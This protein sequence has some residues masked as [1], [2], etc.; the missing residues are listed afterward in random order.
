M[1]KAFCLS[2]KIGYIMNLRKALEKEEASLVEVGRDA[3]LYYDSKVGGTSPSYG[4]LTGRLD[5][6]GANLVYDF[7]MG[8]IQVLP[9]EFL[10]NPDEFVIKSQSVTHENES[11]LQNHRNYVVTDYP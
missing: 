5:S 10:Y 8:T 1:R 6:K 2:S 11:P 7:G 3:L 4:Q 9:V